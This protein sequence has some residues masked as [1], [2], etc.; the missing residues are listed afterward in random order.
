VVGVDG[1]RHER[2]SYRNDHVSLVALDG[3]GFFARSTQEF[4]AGDRESYRRGLLELGHCVVSDNFARRFDVTVGDLIELESPDGPVR[5]PIA[6]VVSNFVS[7]RGTVMIDR[8]VFLAR[9][10]SDRVDMF[11][12]TLAPGADHAAAR[13]AISGRLA[14]EAP[15]IVSTRAEIVEEMHSAFASFYALTRGAATIALIVSLMSVATSLLVS[16]TERTRDIGILKTLGVTN[17]QIAGSVILEAL[18]LSGV[19]LVC[20]VP[21]GS[22][23]AWFLRV[24]VAENAGAFRFPNAYP[25]EVLQPLLVALPIVAIVAALLPAQRAAWLRPSESVSYE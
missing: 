15:A 2:M 18:L 19:A 21:L 9:W 24:R 20:A 16:V 25:Y 6:A 13:L 10:G 11:H 7:D 22:R 12:V 4:V 14:A 23:L 17:A 1:Y 5:L 3:A 8:S